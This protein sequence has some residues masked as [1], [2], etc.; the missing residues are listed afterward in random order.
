MGKRYFTL[1]EANELVPWLE[2]SL[3]QVLRLRASLRTAAVEL[4]RL[5]HPLTEESMAADGGPPE[6][7]SARA[8]ARGLIEALG[9]ALGELLGAGVEVKDLE[10]GL[11][12]FVARRDG[13]DI[14]L[15]WR[16]GE[17]QIEHWH[18]LG[19]GFGG[20]QPLDTGA[21]RLLH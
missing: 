1:A 2:R 8:R 3:G 16:L 11:C 12:D 17:K 14:Y 5:G 7:A 20:R 6:L 13:R 21:A 10:T 9:D 4:E 19:A 15:C 18:E